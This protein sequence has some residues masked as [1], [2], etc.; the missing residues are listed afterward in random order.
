MDVDVCDKSLRGGLNTSCM[1]A[2][3][4]CIFSNIKLDVLNSSISSIS[5]AASLII[6]LSVVILQA[7]RQR[8]KVSNEDVESVEDS[9]RAGELFVVEKVDVDNVKEERGISSEA[10]VLLNLTSSI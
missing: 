7:R 9:T 6:A 10:F 4:V 8:R 2:F 5:K 3:F 1:T